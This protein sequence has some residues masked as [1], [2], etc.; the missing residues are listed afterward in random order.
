[1]R[2][3]RHLQ[4]DLPVHARCDRV[5]SR[6]DVDALAEDITVVSGGVAEVNDPDPATGERSWIASG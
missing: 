4:K 2:S 1:L 5:D 3:E 6:V